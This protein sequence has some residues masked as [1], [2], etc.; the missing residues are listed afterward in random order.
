MKLS[1]CKKQKKLDFNAYVKV[2]R[3][4]YKNGDKRQ[5]DAGTECVDPFE[6]I[7]KYQWMLS[8][9]RISDCVHCEVGKTFYSANFGGIDNWCLFVAPKGFAVT[10]SEADS[11][12]DHLMLYLR[13]LRL[14][15]NIATMAIRYTLKATYTL[16]SN[17]YQE[18]RVK[19]TRQIQVGYGF[20]DCTKQCLASRIP[21]V[22]LLASLCIDVRVEV[23]GMVDMNDKEIPRQQWDAYGLIANDNLSRLSRLFSVGSNTSTLTSSSSTASL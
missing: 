12:A 8:K 4:L 17:L 21:N 15:L 3:V 23:E 10:K 6:Q 20:N 11:A 16:N 14:P 1:E 13:L 7:T 2:L 18:H 22:V 5:I 19:E 9:Q